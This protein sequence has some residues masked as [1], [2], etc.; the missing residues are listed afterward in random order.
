VGF[1]GSVWSRFRTF[2]WKASAKTKIFL[3]ESML[4]PVRPPEMIRLGSYYGGWWVPSIDPTRG[5]AFCVGA[6]TDVTFDL[7]LL[8]LGYRVYT[9]DPTP[10]SVAYVAEHAP[11]LTLLPVGLWR[12]AGELEFARDELWPESWAIGTESPATAGRPTAEASRKAR[13]KPSTSSPSLRVR[14]GM[15]NTSPALKYWGSTSHP[16][17]PAKITRSATRWIVMIS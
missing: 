15:A 8:R 14:H 5:A 4:R 16:T 1:V 11:A 13:P 6:G 17:S 10:E 12:E 9:V 3:L 7:E 2:A